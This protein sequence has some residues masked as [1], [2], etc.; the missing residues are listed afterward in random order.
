MDMEIGPFEA[1]EI[2]DAIEA[3]D[4]LRTVI[5]RLKRLGLLSDDENL[6]T[7]D[8]IQAITDTLAHKL[9]VEE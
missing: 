2:H 8:R 3:C 9:P 4:E 5:S 6:E 7:R 1:M